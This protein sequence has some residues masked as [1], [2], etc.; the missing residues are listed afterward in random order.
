[1]QVTIIGSGYVGLTTG[2]ALAYLGHQVTLVDKNPVVVGSLVNG[3]STIYEYGMDMLMQKARHNINFTTSFAG[4]GSSRVILIAVGTPSKSNGDADLGFVESAVTQ[5]AEQLDGNNYPVIVDKSTVPPGTANRVRTLVNNILIG[6][7]LHPEVN[8]ASNPEFLREGTAFLDALYPDRIVIGAEE[9]STTELLI[10]LNKPIIEQDFVVPASLPRP[11][12]YTGPVLFSTNPLNAELIKYASN[13]FLS[14]KISFINEFAGL[15]ELLNADIIEIAH[16]M[17]LD[18]RIGDKFLRAG[19]GWGGSCFGKDARAILYTAQK[20]GYS[21]PLVQAAIEVNDRQKKLVLSKIRSALKTVPGSTIGIMG[22]AFKPDTDDIRDTPAKDL[23]SEL[24]N[25]GAFIKVYDPMA[26][27]NYKKQYPDLPVEYAMDLENL[28]KGCDA[29]V[30]LTEWEQFKDAD[31]PALRQMMKRYIF[32][33]GRN[34]FDPR[35]MS[36]LGFV[37]CG[38]GRCVQVKELDAAGPKVQL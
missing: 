11:K 33:D 3:V 29:L 32:I 22:L 16:G 20:Y 34:L 21:L 13:A 14:A 35:V 15:A 30:L 10:E 5:I 38:V 26:M 8:V 18:S 7:R 27:D 4:V 28:A 23:I 17:G 24:L 1:M 25:M 2:V 31:L 37:Y 36:E 12:G 19:V 9:Q 6:R